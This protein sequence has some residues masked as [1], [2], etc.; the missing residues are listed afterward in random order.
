MTILKRIFALTFVSLL[1]VSQAHADGTYYL[2]RHAEKQKDAIKDPHLTE[3]GQE[4]AEYFAKQLSLAN[5]TKIYATDYHRTQETAKPLSDLLG[6]AVQ[7]Y[8]AS[9]LEEF[10]QALEA[11]SGN[12]V[13]V[14]HSNTTPVLATLLSGVSV[15]PI[16][17]S[18]YDNLYQVVSVNGK[19]RLTR[20]KILP[21]D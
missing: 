12:I 2:L 3:R 7:S 16:D 19:T 11:E 4:R 15:D 8:N 6:I 18:E 20:F 17:E 13:I 5:I 1:L 9:E 14:G 10:A 21:I